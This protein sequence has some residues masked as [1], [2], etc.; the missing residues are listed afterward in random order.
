MTVG[1]PGD[2]HAAQHQGTVV[3]AA[4]PVHVVPPAHARDRGPRVLEPVQVLGDGDLDVGGLAGDGDHLGQPLH[5]GGVVRDLPALGQGALVRFLQDR[6]LESLGGLH[7]C[8]LGAVQGLG[9]LF[10]V[11]PFDRV[12]HR[13]DRDDAL[14]AVFKRGDQVGQDAGGEE[15]AGRVVDQHARAV[16]GQGAQPV[17]DRVLAALAARGHNPLHAQ[18]LG[19]ECLADLFLHGR[20]VVGREHEDQPL[21][22]RI[23]GEGPGGV[24]EQRRAAVFEILLA[25]AARGF[26]QSPAGAGGQDDAPDVVHRWSPHGPRVDNGRT[27]EGVPPPCGITS[28]SRS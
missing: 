2:G 7:R 25:L 9:H 27:G 10:A 1:P 22:P 28:R 26:G 4:E 15:G 21:D 6:G 14:R 17:A 24:P 8:Q 20:E 18:V 3:L 11:H 19:P 23:A 16:A 13:N 12:G 5:H